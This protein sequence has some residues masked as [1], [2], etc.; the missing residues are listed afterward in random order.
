VFNNLVDEFRVWTLPVL[1]GSGKRLFSEGITAAKLE[2]IKLAACASGA[3]MAFYK[4][5]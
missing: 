2:L 3:F 5:G 1:V 4:S